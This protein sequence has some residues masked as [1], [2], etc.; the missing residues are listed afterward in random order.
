M[1][2]V[3]LALIT[4]ISCPTALAQRYEGAQRDA[5]CTLASDPRGKVRSDTAQLE[6]I[7]ARERFQQARL[8]NTGL[9]E[10]Y[11]ARFWAWLTSL[12]QTGGA[13]TFAEGTRFLVLLLAAVAALFGLLKLV[14][15]RDR[16]QSHGIANTATDAG[17]SLNLASPQTHLSRA[18]ALVGTDARAALR[19]G[20][21][22]LL[23]HLEQAH[24]ARPDR[25]KTNQEISRELPD[26]GAPAAVTAEVREL[27]RD[28]DAL[29]YSLT[30]VSSANAQAV[31]ARV[32]AHCTAPLPRAD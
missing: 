30:P 24:W 26:R 1:T 22:A 19:E 5:V 21:L 32:E 12:L 31:L 29:F 11:L 18:R 25:V 20:L 13:S 2:A 23:S 15:L 14:Q 16:R 4:G 17:A 6:T 9:I 28:Y 7:Y 10:Q 27:M 8:R 3:L